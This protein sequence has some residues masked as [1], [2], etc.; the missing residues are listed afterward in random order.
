M[1]NQLILR[2]IFVIIII[3]VAILIIN[4]L[5]EPGIVN[6]I[7]KI[8]VAIGMGLFLRNYLNNR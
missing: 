8:A 3:I 1:D 6:V 5:V 2:I 7:L 4:S